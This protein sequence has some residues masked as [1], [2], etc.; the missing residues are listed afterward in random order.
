MAA[1]DLNSLRKLVEGQLLRFEG[2]AFQ[3]CMDRLILELYPRD[4]QPVRAAGPKG[5]T[6]NDGYCPKARVFFAAH[7]T[8]GERID[9]TKAK[10]RSDLEGCLKEHRDVKVWR[11]LTNDTLPG[12]VDQFV[13][14]ELRPLHAGVT[15]EVWGLKRLANEICKL[16][17]MQ[18]DRVLD[19]NLETKHR[20]PKVEGTSRGSRTTFLGRPVEDFTDPHALEVHRP[21]AVSSAP[22][23]LP[24]YIARTHDAALR[25]ELDSPGSAL[26][27]LVG[28]SSTGKTRAA[29]EA[30]RAMSGWLLH[31]PIFPS[32]T[33]ALIE[34][35]QSESVAPKTIIWLNELQEYL[36]TDAGEIASSAI[37]NALLDHRHLKFVATVWP[38]HWQDITDPSGPFSSGRELL[39]N[40]ATRIDIDTDF[41]GDLLSSAAQSDVRF[42]L[43]LAASPTKIT[44][45][46]AAGPALLDFF[47]DCK[48]RSPGAWAVLC[49][50]MDG[51]VAGHPQFSTSQFLA[52]A[53]PGYLT[54][55]E[56]GEVGD[57]WFE[58]ALACASVELRGAARP[59]ARI[60][61]RNGLDTDVHYRLADY[62]VQYA[63][64]ERRES[65]APRSFW[66]AV[67]RNAH[68]PGVV[69]TFARAA[70]DRGMHKEAARL[71][72]PLALD[73]DSEALHE[74]LQN[75][76]VAAEEIVPL[77]HDAIDTVPLS[78][79][80][81]LGWILT[82]LYR[83]E[84]L[85][86][87]LVDRISR[88][89][90]ELRIGAPVDM[91]QIL[92]EL[93]DANQSEAVRVYSQ[94]I[95]T[96]LA[97][98]DA[99]DFWSITALSGALLESRVQEANDTGRDLARSYFEHHKIEVTNLAFF[100]NQL[101]S[102]LND[103]TEFI[104][105]VRAELNARIA[106]VDITDVISL[107][108]AI[109][110]LFYA[111]E[112]SLGHLLITRLSKSIDVLNLS[113]SYAPLELMELLYERGHLQ[114]LKQLALKIAKEFNPGLS[115]AALTSLVHL[116][117]VECDEAFA[118]MARRMA[119]SG[120]ILPVAGAEK[121]VN[122][123]EGMGLPVLR[124]IYSERLLDFRRREGAETV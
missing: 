93:D 102:H 1:V 41:R 95:R 48:D 68:E 66:D 79:T 116:H 101:T 53:A 73:G 46:L 59:L 106:E 113:R 11:F 33:A 60:I 25:E 87:R 96:H 56:W 67:L 122:F 111:G 121:L 89:P 100:L 19:I 38:R 43:A 29:Y 34:A 71:W 91:G 31:H 94:T 65:P 12:E 52:E 98:I 117:R 104:D 80:T 18:V 75:P 112:E 3:D 57:D 118:L 78:E 27:V 4:Y 103:D 58:R 124:E 105:E 2:N 69:S 85:K 40:Q 36:M 32:R 9:K 62:L 76:T 55:E 5:D 37:R 15:I 20:P 54:D 120:P 7:A 82:E 64:Q 74:L 10:I 92:E 22:T 108:P 77:I 109:A 90:G 30:V 23:G 47:K 86:A 14:N 107:H 51:Y 119:K 21:I 84:T 42:R 114:A 123:Y 13:D 50:A 63:Q 24:S 99:S 49:A 83:H 110:N 88:S 6:K 81:E 45:Y 26:I 8:R 35:L 39:T 17:R 72:M 97:S 70:D 44:Q 28:G 61:P 115:H 16:T